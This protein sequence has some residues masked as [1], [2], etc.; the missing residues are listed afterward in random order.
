MP[1][2]KP[3]TAVKKDEFN[4]ENV[5]MKET[6]FGKG[7]YNNSK[8]ENFD[9]MK[10]TPEEKKFPPMNRGRPANRDVSMFAPTTT[11]VPL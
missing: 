4:P 5:T 1:S 11:G 10:G 3:Q 9:N 7:E 2:I 6:V 8:L